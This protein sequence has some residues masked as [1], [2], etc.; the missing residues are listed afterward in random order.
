MNKRQ[1][2][3]L[4]KALQKKIDEATESVTYWQKQIERAH[5]VQG[6]WSDRIDGYWDEVTA[7]NEKRIRSER[8][9][10]GLCGYCSMKL[11]DHY[12][13]CFKFTDKERYEK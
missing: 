6:E 10:L 5:E 8:E 7:L 13:A 11:P 4:R 9:E 12:D 2:D 3:K 1:Y